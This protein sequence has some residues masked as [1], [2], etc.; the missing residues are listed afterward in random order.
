MINK[1]LKKIFTLSGNTP[2][3]DGF[4]LLVALLRTINRYSLKDGDG[5][6]GAVTFGIIGAVIYF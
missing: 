3:I 6:N 5:R 1:I 2:L 4:P